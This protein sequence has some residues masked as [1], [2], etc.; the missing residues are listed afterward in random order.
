MILEY[1]ALVTPRASATFPASSGAPSSESG[2]LE[3][4]LTANPQ[5][6]ANA[7]DGAGLRMLTPVSLPVEPSMESRAS[8]TPA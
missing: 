1:L 5:R 7:A 4:V 2:R 3:I 6:V 8:K